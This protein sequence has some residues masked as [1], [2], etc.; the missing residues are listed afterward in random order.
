MKTPP[1]ERRTLGLTIF[2]HIIGLV[3]VLSIIWAGSLI[4]PTTALRGLSVDPTAAPTPSDTP[5]IDI[6]RADYEQALA[7]WRAQKVEE[8]QITTEMRA[9]MG[10]VR[11]LTVKD[12]GN[13]IV[14]LE[15][16]PVRTP[17]PDSFEYVKGDT[18]EG[19]FYE[20]DAML[21]NAQVIHSPAM[22]STGGFYMAYHVEFDPT[23]GYPRFMSGHPVTEPG[24]VVYDADWA[25]VVTELKV[26]KQ[27]K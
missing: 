8:Y 17:E 14:I 16:T 23:I 12:K 9:F 13:S 5:P 3:V 25:K 7:K 20:I 19:M 4:Q 2:S 21:D 27:G 10:G 11:T 22:M 18:I 6:T 15:P 24:V 26:L 1:S